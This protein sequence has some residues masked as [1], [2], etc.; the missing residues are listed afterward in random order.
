MKNLNRAV[1]AGDTEGVK[2]ALA[3]F[4]L[5]PSDQDAAV[6]IK[7]TGEAK[8]NMP[9]IVSTTSG[10]TSAKVTMRVE[11][12]TMEKDNAIKLLWLRDAD[13]GDL[14]TCRELTKLSET[15]EMLQATVPKGKR[16]EPVAYSIK[17]GVWVGEAVST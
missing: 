16:I 17:N 8:G 5:K 10:L 1:L 7:H 3:L 6:A 4:D 11:G 14:I 2:D 9:V 13:T 15:P 12:A